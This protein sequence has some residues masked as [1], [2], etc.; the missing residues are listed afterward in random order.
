M[1]YISLDVCVTG[2]FSHN[3]VV[4]DY[5]VEN[6]QKK[7]RFCDYCIDSQLPNLRI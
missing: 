5:P 1:Y 2:Y 4:V 7:E 3:F 6:Y